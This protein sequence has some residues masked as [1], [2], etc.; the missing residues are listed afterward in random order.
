MR[1]VVVSE[2]GLKARLVVDG[3]REGYIHEITAEGVRTANGKPLL[4]QV[5]YYTLNQFPDGEKLAVAAPAHDHTAMA[6]TAKTAPATAKTAA[7]KKAAAAKPA[8]AKQAKRVTEKPASWTKEADITI[9]L[10]TKPGL[11]FDPTQIRVKAGSKVKVVFHNN[12]DMLHNFVILLPGTAI[13]VGEMAMKLG[14]EGQEKNYIPQT[15]K[16]LYHTKLLQPS[17]TE[18]IYFVAPD[19]PGEY[20]YVCTVPG[21]FYVMQGTLKVVE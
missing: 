2:D 15:D 7:A 3:L 12:D 5:G 14:L 21:H 20:T 6:S 4:H 1:A 18:A 13:E 19:K 9:N 8:A 17:E 11:K 16:L 10:G